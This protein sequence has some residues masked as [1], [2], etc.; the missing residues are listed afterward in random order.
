MLYRKTSQKSNYCRHA[1]CQFMSLINNS[2]EIKTS[3]YKILPLPHYV[4]KIPCPHKK[5]KK[6]EGINPKVFIPYHITVSRVTSI[7]HFL[8]LSGFFFFPRKK[9]NKQHEN[10][11]KEKSHIIFLF[12]SSKLVCCFFFFSIRKARL[13]QK[14]LIFQTLLA[15]KYCHLNSLILN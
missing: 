8:L 9:S 10:I 12:H 1:L 11:F 4:P 6:G 2:S 7:P 5:K 3:I 15:G 14:R 13:S